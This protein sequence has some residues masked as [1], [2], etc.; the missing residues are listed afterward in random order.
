[1]K[2]LDLIS[3]FSNAIDNAIEALD[4]IQDTDDRIL[5]IALDC[6]PLDYQ[7]IITNTIKE[8]HNLNLDLLFTDGYTTKVN[9]KQDHGKGLVIMKNIISNTMASLK[10]IYITLSFSINH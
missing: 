2:T 1:M 10:L 4:C 6:D 3:L 7:F 5:N 8:G 9:K